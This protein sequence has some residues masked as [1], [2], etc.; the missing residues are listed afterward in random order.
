MASPA[1]S[2]SQPAAAAAAAAPASADP[3]PHAPASPNT[4]PQPPPACP[5]P[6][7]PPPAAETAQPLPAHSPQPPST[8]LDATMTSPDHQPQ[9]EPPLAVPTVP[10]PGSTE[11]PAP[12]DSGL[13][14]PEPLASMDAAAI[15]HAP[16]AAAGEDESV[17]LVSAAPAA[18]A[19]AQPAAQPAAEPAA[20]QPPPSPLAPCTAQEQAALSGLAALSALADQAQ[21]Q[22]RMPMPAA[23]APE[24]PA[25]TASDEDATSAAENMLHAT[26]ADD[27]VSA[28]KDPG[29]MNSVSDEGA[30]DSETLHLSPKSSSVHGAQ[31]RL[32]QDEQPATDLFVA[33]RGEK[34]GC[35]CQ[36]PL[37]DRLFSIQCDNCQEWFHGRSVRDTWMMRLPLY[38]VLVFHR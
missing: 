28:S 2:P 26:G 37:D 31:D 12:T 33:Q 22:E 7:A 23:S 13:L 15:D 32:A 14:P 34:S 3:L 18:P 29:Q 21:D 27:A 5:A 1:G 4:L 38:C 11:P 9:T 17:P 20:E 16:A 25:P 36:Q 8:G 24:A 19:A 10:S 30:A 6:L 35:L